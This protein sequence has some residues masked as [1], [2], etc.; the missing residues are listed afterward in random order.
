[1][2]KPLPFRIRA[3]SVV[4]RAVSEG[5]EYGYRRAHKHV[6]TPAEDAIL[7]AIE[8]AVMD[9]LSEVIDWGDA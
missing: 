4:A 3:Y 6:D 7:I 2:D 1:L 9:E 8:E 5:V